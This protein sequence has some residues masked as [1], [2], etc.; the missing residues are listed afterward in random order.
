MSTTDARPLA[1]RVVVVTGGNGGIGLGLARGVGAAGAAVSIW[2]RNEAKNAAAAEELRAR[3]ARAEAVV[4]DVSDE[5]AVAAAFAATVDALGPVDALFANAGV[6]GDM[7][8]FTDLTY[9]KWRSVLSVNL[10][11]TFFCLREAARHMVEQGRGGALVGVSS[12]TS[13]YGA[14]QKEA[15]G[16]SKAGIEALMR[17]LAVELAPHRI[18]ANTLLPGWTDTDLLGP[19]AGFIDAR[20]HDLVKKYTIRRTP[21]GRWGSLDDFASAAAFLADPTATFHTGDRLVIDGG[22]TVF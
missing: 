3:G 9:A 10:D 7:C 21:A 8:P 1:G 17:A 5:A 11:G 14:A 20:N 22:Y 12:I 2:G 4:C 18:R 15:Y 16:V 13:F 6:P 19:G